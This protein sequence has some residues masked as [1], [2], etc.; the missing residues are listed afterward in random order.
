THQ[1]ALAAAG[2]MASRWPRSRSVS[3]VAARIPG[4]PGSAG[5]LDSPVDSDSYDGVA[6]MGNI[7]FR[8]VTVPLL[9]DDAT[10]GTLYVATSLDREYAQELERLAGNRIAIVSD[11]LVLATTL[12]PAA[13][14]QFESAVAVEKP[15]DGT[16]SLDG[17]AY[18][19]R[20]LVGLGDTVFYA[21]GSIAE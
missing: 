18:A 21:L 19:F 3:L 4:I 8:V 16:I 6:R 17:E 2:R 20:R 7:V 5:G 10:I 15:V 9:L 1:V 13:A 12:S 14:R 11:G